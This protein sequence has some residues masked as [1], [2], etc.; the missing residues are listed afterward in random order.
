M[1]DDQWLESAYSSYYGGI[2]RYLVRIVGAAD[3]EDIAQETFLKALKAPDDLQ[4]G[5]RSWLFRVATNAALDRL[6]S[7]SRVR[8]SPTPFDEEP[9][10]AEGS[11][12]A[13]AKDASIEAGTIQAEMSACVRAIEDRLPAGQRLALLLSDYEGLSDPEIATVLG[14][15]VGSVKARLHRAR[16]RLRVEM[17]ESCRIYPDPANQMACEPVVP[18]SSIL[19]RR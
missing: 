9:L 17:G 10:V 6:R 7:A 13:R 3:A 1:K 14:V 15:S 5:T 16:E 12:L 2:R 8:T 11:E 18:L 4:E 19:R